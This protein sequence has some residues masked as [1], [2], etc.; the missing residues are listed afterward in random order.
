[1]NRRDPVVF[2][3]PPIVEKLF[4]FTYD[5]IYLGAAIIAARLRDAGHRVQ[6]ID[7]AVDCRDIAELERRL[8]ALRPQAV[9][10]PA[11][12]GTVANVYRVAGAARRLGVPR[13]IVGGLPASFAWQRLLAECPAID[14]CVLGE[15][16]LAMDRLV[17][18]DDPATIP[19]LAYRRDGLPVSTGEPQRLPDL[20][21]NPRPARE[22]FPLRHYRT[23]SFLQGRDIA[24]T[25]LETKRGCAFDCDFCT[26]SPKE[27][28]QLRTR[29][30][31]HVIAELAHIRR[32]H[33]GI[34]RVM[35][36]D[37][38]FFTPM[39]QAR[40]ILEGIIEAGLH[41]EHEYMI[42]TRVQHF[43]RHGEPLIDLCDRANVRLVYF[44][45]ESVSDASRERL[46]KIRDGWDVAGLFAAMQ[47]RRVWNV[48]SYM[49]GFPEE[50][51][52]DL[53]ATIQASI[54]HRPTMVKYN[55][56]TPY[57]GTRFHRDLAER[58]LL[59]P[60]ALTLLD[61]AHQVFEHP[62]DLEAAF[63]RA[64]RQYY[65]TPSF[66]RLVRPV[67]MLTSGDTS[68][69]RTLGHHFARHE[70]QPM[71]RAGARRWRDAVC[72]D[73]FER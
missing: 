31:A 22:L 63:H 8:A 26:Q 47:A 68:R 48:G 56:V 70:L 60:H 57:P 12:Y 59:R 15:G 29:S 6:V 71:L 45:V 4:T 27:G 11:I 13:V 33:P 36:V 40:G 50:G 39:D 3:I 2:V 16:E 53:A 25:T 66:A 51:A 24:S 19:G 69:F 38:D 72:P 7:C 46:G 37:N 5:E 18:G 49:L 14:L 21:S 35:I 10:I 65:V 9:A 58:G 55:I 64:W 42:A 20:E 62:L 32:R 1:M 52:A 41:R 30:P 23:W 17:A 54:Q 28:R 43:Q 44:G 34:Q 61:N 67:R 73:D